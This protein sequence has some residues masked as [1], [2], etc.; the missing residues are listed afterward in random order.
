MLKWI[1]SYLSNRTQKVFVR[2]SM[3]DVLQVKAGV[4]QGS[5]LG[6]LFFLIY[7]NDIV[8]NLLSITRLFADDTSLSCTTSH[9]SDIE[10]IVNH[11]LYQINLW[12]KNWL[13]DFNPQKTEAI[14]FTTQ[15]MFDYLNFI[16]ITFR[17]ILLK[18]INTLV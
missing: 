16:L 13:V 15:K 4:P 9:L 5:V 17:L 3:S 6:P 18:V 14:L 1:E 8:N 10:G 12:A 2:S 11:D 7:V